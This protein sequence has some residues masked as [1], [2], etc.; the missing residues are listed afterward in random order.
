MPWINRLFILLPLLFLNAVNA[1]WGEG[2]DP[3][4]PPVATTASEGK[5]EVI[6]FFWYGCPHCY[7]MEP[8]LEEWLKNKP[9]NVEFI[10]VPAP[11]NS[12]WTVHA[13]FFYA[14]EILGLTEKLH[15]PLFTAIHDKK[16]KLY[17]K[18]SLIDF[19][20]EHGADR[21]Q[22]IDA[23]NSFGVYVK[24]QN[25]RKLGQR[26]QLDGVPAIGI[27]GKYKTSGSLAGTYSKMFEIVTQLVSKE[28]NTTP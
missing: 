10:R 15:N 13:Q 17:D 18:D 9:E 4:D 11:L 14:A 21:Q 5:V 20:V 1:E 16:R 6:E 2:W 27:N 19:A 24:V 25:A 7:H 26:Y 23:L 12:K 28:L 22:F 3:I 8:Q